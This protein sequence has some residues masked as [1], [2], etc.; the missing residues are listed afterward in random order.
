VTAF[1][2]TDSSSL[3]E[4]NASDEELLRRCACGNNSALEELVRRYQ[5]ALGRLLS[6]LLSSSDQAGQPAGQP[7][8]KKPTALR[9]AVG[10]WDCENS[11]RIKPE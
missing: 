8:L 1:E 10:V 3:S 5:P 9:G 11:D 2:T 4:A 6:R 7:N